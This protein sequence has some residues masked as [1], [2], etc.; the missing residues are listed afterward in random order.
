MGTLFIN[1]THAYLGFAI[2]AMAILTIL[3]GFM[4]L[5]MKEKRMRIIHRWAGRITI[6]LMLINIAGGWLMISS[7]ME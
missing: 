7:G 3:G 2:A 6:A 4:Q 1:E 5:Q